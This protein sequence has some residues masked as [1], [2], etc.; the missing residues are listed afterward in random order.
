MV[1]GPVGPILSGI[2]FPYV[3]SYFVGRF[4]FCSVGDVWCIFQ[5]A[6]CRLLYINQASDSELK[7]SLVRQQKQKQQW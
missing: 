6:A 4:E 2:F 7:H 3:Y 5:S 1:K